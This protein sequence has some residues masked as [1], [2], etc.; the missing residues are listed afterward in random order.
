M[1]TLDALRGAAILGILAMNIRNYGLGLREFDNPAHPQPPGSPAAPADLWSWIITNVFFEDKMIA[2]LSMLF[3]AGFI[4]FAD[5][6]HSG[7][8]HLRRMLWLL[9][10]GLFHAYI[11]WY[12]DILNTYAFCG[13]ILWPLRKLHPGL[14]IALGILC[15]VVTVWVRVGPFMT[16]SLE[17]PE[18]AAAQKEPSAGRKIFREAIRTEEA[19]YRGGYAG[20]FRWRFELNKV[21][22]FYSAPTFSL[23]R[24]WGYMLLGMALLRV[25]VL[26]GSRSLAFYLALAL[27][28]YAGGL[29]L[30]LLGFY[31]SLAEAL[32]REI[33]LGADGAGLLGWP[34]RFLGAACIAVGHVGALLAL[35]KSTS[36]ARLLRPFAAV[37]RTALTVYLSQTLICIAI[38]DGWAF[39]QWNR[40]TM[41]Q[42]YAL[43]VGIWIA[44]PIIATLWL[45]RFDVGPAEWL[46]RSLTYWRFLPFRT[47]RTPA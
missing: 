31:P 12:G 3:G 30:T 37:G 6:L 19:A 39:G 25:G 20:L 44:Q 21:W 9:A 18:H 28:S 27:A 41:S 26:N 36:A 45:K 23:W 10:I 11:L 1:F 35:C 46:W 29:T 4:V 7:A 42:L 14:L 38:F 5:R 40:W 13:L 32:G 34:L 15:L 2:I 8:V 33:K 24:S 16:R 47:A 43:V 22:H 17:P